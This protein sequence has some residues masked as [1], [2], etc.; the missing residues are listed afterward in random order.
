MS[1]TQEQ[2]RYVADLQAMIDGL[3]NTT[4]SVAQ[5]LI[6]R[7][8]A[9]EGAMDSDEFLETFGDSK[10]EWTAAAALMID[11]ANI[12]EVVTCLFSTGMIK[13][14]RETMEERVTGEVPIPM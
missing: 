2:T 5:S 7:V 6:A 10:E 14:T 1:L 3:K 13:Q 12:D 8:K 11:L 4:T 9:I